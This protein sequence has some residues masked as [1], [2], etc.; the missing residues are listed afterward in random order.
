MSKIWCN[1]TDCWFNAKCNCRAKDTFIYD[2][3]CITCR[4]EKPEKGRLSRDPEDVRRD[5]A[6]KKV[7]EKIMTDML[8]RMRL[9]LNRK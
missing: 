6:A 2:G 5:R 3:E 4:Y 8:E 1:E 9:E 7:A